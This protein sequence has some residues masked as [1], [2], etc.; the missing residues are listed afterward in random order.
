MIAPYCWLI[1]SLF[2]PENGGST[3]LRN[4][5]ELLA[6]LQVFTSEKTKLFIVTS[7]ST[8]DTEVYYNVRMNP[9]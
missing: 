9:P 3:F 6:R 5:A 1:G 2:N 4:I 7:V 8:S